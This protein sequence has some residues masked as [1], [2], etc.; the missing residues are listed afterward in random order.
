MDPRTRRRIVIA[1][2]GAGLLV[3]PLGAQ[4]RSPVRVGVYHNP[5]KITVSETGM[6]G[7]F[8]AELIEAIADRAG[9]DIT[10]VPGEWDDL[11]RLTETGSIDIMVD[12]AY[13]AERTRRFAFNEESV[14]VNWGVVYTPPTRV[15][16]SLADLTSRRIAT[17]AGSIHTTGETGIIALLDSLGVDATI[18]ELPNYTAVFHAVASGTADAAVV[19]RVFGATFDDE[20]GLVRTPIIFNPVAIRYALPPDSPRTLELV[21]TLDR[22]LQALKGDQSSVYFALIDRY[23][24]ESAVTRETIPAWLIAILAIAVSALLALAA[25]I[26]FLLRE[27]AE[28]RAAEARLRETQQELVRADRMRSMGTL[29]A[30]VAHELNNPTNYIAGSVA[31]MRRDVEEIISDATRGHRR[32]ATIREIWALLDGV[33]EG[34]RRVSSVAAALRAY[35][36]DDAAPMPIDPA[37]EIRRACSIIEGRVAGEVELDIVVEELP[38]IQAPPG[39]LSAAVLAVLTNALEAINDRPLQHTQRARLSLSAREE[40]NTSDGVRLIHIRVSD[41]GIGMPQEV[42]DRATD[43]FFSTRTAPSG[44]T[45]GLG[46]AVCY[47]TITRLGGTIAIASREAY[48]TTVDLRVPIPRG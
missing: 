22:E 8:H 19:N 24:A 44:A 1:M 17:M 38:A 10:Y 18:V 43:P 16:Q 34:A 37:E 41:T 12:V 27:I 7:G 23:L 11:L 14:L 36:R 48:G 5:P 13:S 2:L 40:T 45:R 32:D 28:R 20:Y 3:L 33:E 29:I 4:D 30:G 39:E 31:G 46:L 15:V 26:I 35:V 42:L 25:L 9:W 6:A 21:A 47:D